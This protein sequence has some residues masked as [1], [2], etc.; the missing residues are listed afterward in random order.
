[1]KLTS[2]KKKLEKTLALTLA[3]VML[4]GIMPLSVMADYDTP[5]DGGDTPSVADPPGS[6]EPDEEPKDEPKDEPGK[7]PTDGESGNEPPKGDPDDEPEDGPENL[8][9]MASGYI[10]T[11]AFEDWDGTKLGEQTVSQ[12]EF[13]TPPVNP[14]LGSPPRPGFVFSGWTLRG[15][16][17]NAASDGWWDY[18][19]VINVDEEFYIEADIE[20]W[21]AVARYT[22][23]SPGDDI[24]LNAS[25]IPDPNFRKV[26]NN[27]LGRDWDSTEPIK[28]SDVINLTRLRAGWNNIF[29]LKGVEYFT[30][31]RSL[32]C[33]NN[34]L[35]T[36]DLSSNIA[37]LELD[38]ERNRITEIN[39]SNNNRL[40]DLRASNNRLTGLDLTNNPNIG[41]LRVQRNL[42][43]FNP[44]DLSDETPTRAA[45]LGIDALDFWDFGDPDEPNPWL[46]PQNVI[47]NT[48]VVFE[49]P[50]FEEAVRKIIGIPD[51]PII[52]SDVSDITHLDVSGDWEG[53]N[54]G[55][56]T[57]LGGIEF[58][59][60]LEYLRADYNELSSIGVLGSLVNLRALHVGD[61][62]LTTLDV[63]S[64]QKLMYLNVWDNQLTTISV[65]SLADLRELN[66]GGNSLTD[67]D[68]SNNLK[69]ESLFVWDNQL[70]ELDVSILADLR[71]LSVGGNSLTELD[72]SKNLK[73]QDLFVYDNQ[74]TSLDVSSN[75][76]LELLDVSGNKLE[77]ALDLSNHHKLRYLN[78]YNNK[79]TSIT[80]SPDASFEFID[81]RYN[82]M[83][84]ASPA[85]S[86]FG[87]SFNWS[88]I[89][90]FGDFMYFPQ[91]D[92]GSHAGVMTV[93]FE[94][95]NGR[96]LETPQ[97]IEIGNAATP[98]TV[99][100]TRTNFTFIGW[101][102]YDRWSWDSS[103]TNFNDIK[104]DNLNVWDGYNMTVFAMYRRNT[105]L[106]ITSDIRDPGF[107]EHVRWLINKPIG[108][109]MLNDVLNI[110]NLDIWQ[111]VSDLA[112]IQHFT[113]LRSLT[114]T[115]SN[116][117]ALSLG[118][119]I[120]LKYLNCSNNNLTALSL[121]NNVFLEE[122]N[123]SYNR[124]NNLN[125]SGNSR[126]RYLDCSFNRLSSISLSNNRALQS[127]YINN[128]LLT[129][130][131]L[132]NNQDIYELFCQRNLMLDE[133]AVTG[134]SG[135]V[136]LRFSPQNTSFT[137]PDVNITG[138]FSDRNFL[139]AVR[140]AAGK[141]SGNIMASDV[142][143]ISFLNI[144]NRD[145]S[146]LAGI[147]HFKNLE[148]LNGDGNRLTSVDLSELKELTRLN[149]AYN[150]L[151]ALDVSENKKL[152]TLIIIGN[153]IAAL[154]VS[155][156]TDL[157][158]LLCDTNLLTELDLS[159]NPDLT[160]LQCRNNQLTEL[161]LSDNPM[162]GYLD[163]VNNEITHIILNDNAPIW[164]ADVRLNQMTS[165]DDVFG[166]DIDWDTEDEWGWVELTFL[167]QKTCEFNV[168]VVNG[169]DAGTGKYNPFA[170]VTVT[171]DVPV[172]QQ[173]THW[174]MEG[175]DDWWYKVDWD[176][177]WDN[178]GWKFDANSEKT[179]FIMPPHDVTITANFGIAPL[180]GTATINIPDGAAA[181]RIG[182]E[183]TASLEGGNNT[184]TLSYIWRRSGSTASIGTSAAYT[185]QAADLGRTLTVEIRSSVQT[186]AMTS[187]ASLAVLRTAGPAAPGVP[188]MASRT[189]NSVTLEATAGHEYSRTNGS[190]WQASSTFTG[191]SP[192]TEYTFI[193]RVAATAGRDASDNSM[194]LTVT[195][196]PARPAQP[197][198]TNNGPFAVTVTWAAA[199]GATSY[200]VWRKLQSA[201]VGAFVLEQTLPAGTISWE[202]RTIE[203]STRYSYAIV[204]VAGDIRSEMS[205]GRD[206]ANLAAVNRATSPQP[207][208]TGHNA[209]NGIRPTEA[210][211]TWAAA[212]GT[213][214]GAP[215]G[216]E[217]WRRISGQTAYEKISGDDPIA[218]AT[219]EERVFLDEDVVPGVIYDYMIRTLWARLD[220]DGN[221][222]ADGSAESVAR[223]FTAPLQPTVPAAF[224]VAAT[225]PTAA[226]FTWTRIPGASGYEIF[227]PG[228][229]AI[230]IENTNPSAAN[231][232]SGASANTPMNET[233]IDLT[234]GTAYIAMIRAYWG[235]DPGRLYGAYSAAISFTAPNPAPGSVRAVAAS[236]TAVTVTWNAITGANA[237]AG[238]FIYKDGVEI[239]EVTATT[240][241][242]PDTGVT[243]L[244]PL[245]YSVRAFWG[246]DKK[247][248]AIGA[249]TAV[250]PPGP[251]P[252]QP[253]VVTSSLSPTS[254][255]L[256]WNLANNTNNAGVDGFLIT[257]LVGTTV[258][259]RVKIKREPDSNTGQPRLNGFTWEDENL[260]PGIAVS[261]RVQSLWDYDNAVI[262]STTLELTGGKPGL[263]STARAVTATG[264]IPGGIRAVPASEMP[265]R[266]PNPTPTAIT[267]DWNRVANAGGMT[268]VQYNVYLLLNGEE[269]HSESGVEAKATTTR[270]EQV[271]FTG[272][273]PNTQY[274]VQVQAVW[275]NAA[276]NTIE[277]ARSAATN[278]T[279]TA[280]LAVA[281]PTQVSAT[282]T[283]VIL[284]WVPIDG[285]EGYL[286][287]KDGVPYEYI[288]DVDFK[289]GIDINGSPVANRWRD[290]EIENPGTRIRYNVRVYWTDPPGYTTGNFD[291]GTP[292][293][294]SGNRDVTPPGIAPTQP[295]VVAGSLS[296]TSVELT[297]NLT[298][299]INNTMDAGLEG[300]LITKLVGTTVVDRFTVGRTEPGLTGHTWK[301][302][303]LIPGVAVSYRVQS[304][305][306]YSGA[307]V[308]PTTKE[309]T[310]GKPGLMSTARAVT[311]T[312]GIPGGIRAVPNTA[313]APNPTPTSIAVD[314][315][316]V[317]DVGGMEAVEYN[318]YLLLGGTVVDSEMGVPA[319]RPAQ[320]SNVAATRQVPDTGP[321][322]FENLLP[323]TQYQVQVQAVWQGAGGTPVDGGRS[324]A[325]N[326]TRTT[327]PVVAAPAQISATSTSVILGWT[328]LANAAGYLV[329]K[330]GVPYE[331]I[332][333]EDFRLAA[334]RW[335]DDVI[336]NPGTRI[337]YNVRVYWVDPPDYAT[338]DFSDGTSGALSG[339]RDV[340]P[341]G[342][343]PTGVA[344]ARTGTQNILSQTGVTLTWVP[345][346][347][348]NRGEPSGYLIF[349]DGVAFE[350]IT[351]TAFATGLNIGGVQVGNRWRDESLNPGVAVRYSVRTVWGDG[352]KLEDG[353]LEDGTM[354]T[355]SNV[356]TVTP[357]GGAAPAGVT[358]AANSPTQ[359][360]VTWNA[361]TGANAA[362][363][364]RFDIHLFDTQRNELVES[365]SRQL[366]EPRNVVFT[367]L[368][369]NTQYQVRVVGIW[370][371]TIDNSDPRE[372]RQTAV[373][374]RTTGPAP[375][376]LR[377]AAGS[378]T[379]T[380]VRLMWN[381]VAH[382]GVVGYR[383]TRTVNDPLIP[384]NQRVPE[385]VA[386]IT[387][388]QYIENGNSWTDNDLRPGV[389]VTYLVQALWAW[390][391]HAAPG[392]MGSM[393]GIA[394]SLNVTPPG[395][396]P[397]GV[398]GTVNNPMQI[399]V[400]WNVVPNVAGAIISGYRVELVNITN[401]NDIISYKDIPVEDGRLAVFTG[402]S[403]GTQYRINVTA[404]WNNDTV[405]GRTSVNVNVR[406]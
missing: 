182:D 348:A 139:A 331:Y 318:V 47:D 147:G 205:L 309:V 87:Q 44:A 239:G 234:P 93:T 159:N 116:L 69:L 4:M 199:N 261:Y 14:A 20:I 370:D 354:G 45:I 43:P 101:G 357:L 275:E 49:C 300:F 6:G 89:G 55:S 250:T 118:S 337:R 114:V 85:S 224:R 368:N 178:C 76:M 206:M 167:P 135:K 221:D 160:N 154:D 360:T 338:G 232:T 243:P 272:L 170:E 350:Y 341:P 296:P 267:V 403:P 120:A 90:L 349:K 5:P 316:G 222:T 181:P 249:A 130:L 111:N 32:Y 336:E 29:D 57:S 325:V 74:L 53:E 387:N 102:V 27:E 13:V 96:E 279:R 184:G 262:D 150:R 35:T 251:A 21:G 137:G 393:P 229:G 177:D 334:N 88:P 395:A 282:S 133:S 301:D 304:L 365:G 179:T 62:R 195:T 98:P 191:L 324:A 254:V 347:V 311:A 293:A 328:P 362:G 166:V 208:V 99:N 28:L 278:V 176:S 215:T 7:E 173:F 361:I 161:D 194:V 128:N 138:A 260:I 374:V 66:V 302:E 353:K 209:T 158:Q 70:T 64:N 310:G 41:L 152:D 151:T 295:A 343:N 297:W 240:L 307:S 339:N 406:T 345:S 67:L 16:K 335:R 366:N 77:G 2:I 122:L 391:E 119:N 112:G 276:G 386:E 285:A 86:V 212:T 280:N 50:H 24:E 322:T 219:A 214:V 23:S 228:V 174:T 392:E 367:D 56:I 265:G 79:L 355:L 51:A 201:A 397:G 189:H 72:V 363:L 242:F 185:V 377:A 190:T 203:E 107:R 283:S 292:G 291:G 241:S 40:T 383:M 168:T 378:Q 289:A 25:H 207:T 226:D 270:Q 11:I 404:L 117:S 217:V 390:D 115:H 165:Y 180:S 231:V 400:T 26:I 106:N 81:V 126:L 104:W 134:I 18:E 148:I 94:D 329:M 36:L 233:A 248:G 346:S 326:V 401:P 196:L 169:T 380:S 136:N 266:T 340:T 271:R 235:E 382:H 320:G 286:V 42:M 110:T 100:P 294:L 113:S 103:V 253:A 197:T 369:P 263:M 22:P 121:T 162:L 10:N 399:T 379:G 402:L 68:V 175:C 172:G 332:T 252:T 48:P 385:V 33:S 218:G 245:N 132:T 9:I 303:S 290:D 323:N 376:S 281:A 30:S 356:L 125:L 153:R 54:R 1:M 351:N 227:I 38:C 375:G 163:C 46:L 37:L 78:A 213:G 312:G 287:I 108:N 268:V 193:Q 246:D 257:K 59:E 333:D 39:L 220:S 15:G 256:T 372:G 124:I 31:I 60:A 319:T 105:D 84:R 146:D 284:G 19:T 305:W 200:E 204:V 359:I 364:V 97:T 273:I 65:S 188:V 388:S 315:L 225:R 396:V 149:L 277:G 244:V 384:V 145:I 264:G 288:A 371:Y 123:C 129:G 73:L 171:A 63:G 157:R 109:I 306:D 308:D 75:P 143:N 389:Q 58:F 92:Y 298:N 269:V 83:D 71:G 164:M 186:G 34:N 211:V 405:I 314:W 313:A 8:E 131:D 237:P 155:D 352:A 210:R 12:G 187:A 381:A 398:S 223:Q 317:N 202:D 238:Y 141:S 344:I 91:G 61:N 52:K 258:V 342:A 3:F 17:Y 373:N 156:N 198:I 299:N 144:W 330:D 274:Q 95:W 127:L 183:L 236:P 358:G 394:A 327:N 140:L 80:L 192:S 216:Y 82:D 230:E 142:Y 259:D 247:P 321:V 255:E